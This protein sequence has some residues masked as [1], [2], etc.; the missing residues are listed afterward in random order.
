MSLAEED[1]IT[2]VE[3]ER[4]VRGS[5]T[6][7]TNTLFRDDFLYICDDNASKKRRNYNSFSLPLFL[8]FAGTKILSYGIL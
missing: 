3:R 8:F 6:T 2:A 1:L 7:T 5:T 4:V